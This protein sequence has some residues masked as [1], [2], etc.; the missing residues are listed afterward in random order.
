MK[1]KSFVEE[2]FFHTFF[3]FTIS[4]HNITEILNTNVNHNTNTCAALTAERRCKVK[5]EKK[6]H[7]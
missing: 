7:D 3:F 4:Q 2:Y 5:E 1:N 6:A